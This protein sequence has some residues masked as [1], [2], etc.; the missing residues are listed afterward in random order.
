MVATFSTVGL[1]IFVNI[2]DHCDTIVLFYPVHRHAVSNSVLHI[3]VFVE[4]P[5]LD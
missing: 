3:I 5:I 4:D 1:H 2:L